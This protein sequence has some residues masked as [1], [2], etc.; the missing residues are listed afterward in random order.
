MFCHDLGK[1]RAEVS[2]L[3]E[4]YQWTYCW[5]SIKAYFDLND[6]LEDYRTMATLAVFVTQLILK[7]SSILK[8]ETF[9]V[10]GPA[11]MPLFQ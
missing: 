5:W 6:I 9:N 4:N 7:M 1:L 3:I 10:E 11:L 8:K 2:A